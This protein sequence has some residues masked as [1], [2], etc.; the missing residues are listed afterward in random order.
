VLNAGQRTFS[1]SNVYFQIPLQGGG[2]TTANLVAEGTIAHYPTFAAATVDPGTTIPCNNPDGATVTLDGRGTIDPYNQAL[3]YTWWTGGVL[4]GTPVGY[5]PTLNVNVPFGTTAYSLGVTDTF[6]GL[7]AASTSV[8]VSNSA[9]PILTLEAPNPACI[10]PANGLYYIY[11]LGTD[12]PYQVS[13][14]CASAQPTVTITDVSSSETSLVY[15]NGFVFNA[16]AVCVAAFN[17]IVDPA[18]PLFGDHVYTVTVQAKDQS[19]STTTKLTSIRIAR[20]WQPG[21]ECQT[22]PTNRVTLFPSLAADCGQIGVEGL[23]Q[24]RRR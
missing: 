1:L 6:L 21:G 17:D 13:A 20:I 14:P 19:G 8:T 24:P 12:I 18:E 11:R 5:G 15:G 16:N 7:S 9:P 22:P 4:N 23:S 10:W 3:A 2:A